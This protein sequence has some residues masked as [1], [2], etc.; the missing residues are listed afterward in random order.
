MTF[1]VAAVTASLVRSPSSSSWRD[2]LTLNVGGDLVLCQVLQL[3]LC[4]ADGSTKVLGGGVRF[5]DHLAAFTG[6]RFQ[7]VEF[8]HGSLLAHRFG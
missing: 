3:P 8:A 1:W 7:A 4:F 5:A 2:D 6:R